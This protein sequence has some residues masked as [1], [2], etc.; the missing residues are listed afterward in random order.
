[1]TMVNVLDFTEEVD[2]ELLGWDYPILSMPDYCAD[3]SEIEL[4]ARIN[5]LIWD[6]AA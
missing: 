6:G 5:D 2:D 4:V 3:L 1:M